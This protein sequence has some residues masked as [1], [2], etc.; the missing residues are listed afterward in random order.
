MADTTT[1]TCHSN[2][3]I[4]SSPEGHELC[5]EIIS[6]ELGYSPHDYQL[7]GVCRALDGLDLLAITPTGSGKTGFLIMYFIVIRAVMKKPELCVNPPP[8]FRKDPV[9]VVVCPTLA[10]EEDM[11]VKFIS[12]GISALVINKNTTDALRRVEAKDIWDRAPTTEALL[13]SPEQLSSPGFE[14]LLKVKGY[15]ARVV[16]LGVDEVHLLNTWGRTI[17]PDFEQIGPMRS[18]FEHRPLI[19]ALTATLLAGEPTRSVCRFL[20]LHQGHYH[21]IR[22]SNM[23]YDIRFVFRTVQSG[24]RAFAYPELDWV[25]TGNRRIIIFCPTIALGFRVAT[26]LRA[27]SEGLEDLDKRIRMYNSVNWASYM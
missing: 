3:F 14:H 20:G 5:R 7:E 9:I 8:H 24:A 2:Y 27:R 17:R 15:Q 23:R 16:A 12:A 10:L 21:L 1:T 6:G 26:Y 19:I 22:R 25:L 13:L 4:F 18:R 11:D